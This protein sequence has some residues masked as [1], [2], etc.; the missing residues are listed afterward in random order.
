MITDL[1]RIK[2][3]RE[4]KAELEVMR[5]RTE[6]A[7]AIDVAAKAR[8]ALVDYRAW[9]LQRERD[10]YADICLKVVKSRE[11]EWLR[12]DVLLLRGRERALDQ[13]IVDADS[14]TKSAEVAARTARDLHGIAKRNREKFDELAAGIAA[15]LAAESVRK[16]ETEM[17][18]LYALRRDR[19][20]WGDDEAD[21]PAAESS[22][23]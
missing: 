18:D 4:N 12:E 7:H 3:F 6:L 2:T 23:A 1:V 13:E 14:A 20:D 17:E 15:E 19:L 8:Q 5:K 9:S 10:M 16:E 22:E 21:R 11:I